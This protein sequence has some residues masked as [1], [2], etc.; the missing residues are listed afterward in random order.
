VTF[1]PLAVVSS[2]KSHSY[3][4]M[5]SPSRSVTAASKAIVCPRTG[6]ESEIVKLALGGAGQRDLR[7]QEGQGR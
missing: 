3:E 5:A 4:V 6:V 1:W 7:R 2:P